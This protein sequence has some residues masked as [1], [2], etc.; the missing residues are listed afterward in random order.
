VG[1]AGT[2]EHV[3]AFGQGSLVTV[4]NIDA[5]WDG[6]G[7]SFGTTVGSFERSDRYAYS[8]REW[9]WSYDPQGLLAGHSEFVGTYRVGKSGL[10]GAGTLTLYGL[11]EEVLFTEPLTASGRKLEP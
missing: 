6:Q 2:Y 3:Y 4:G 11:G 7:A 9:T 1:S 10:T 8:V 5:N